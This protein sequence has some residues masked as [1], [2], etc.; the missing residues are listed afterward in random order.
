MKKMILLF[1]CLLGAL[2][3]QAQSF[4]LVFPEDIPASAT[5]VLTQ[6]FSQMLQGGGFKLA[7]DG[8]PI[9][10]TSKIVSRDVTQ[11]AL[12]QVALEIELCAD[13]GKAAETFVIKGV[14]DDD[15]DA[16]VRAAKQLLPRSKTAQNFVQKLK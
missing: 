3:L 7:D 9:T 16:W 10:L 8:V 4:R 5:E 6:R 11:G 14:G 15:A 13:A 12:G 1:C 2:S